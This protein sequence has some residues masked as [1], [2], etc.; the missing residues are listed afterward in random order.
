VCFVNIGPKER[1]K[2]LL[3]GG[4]S[5]AVGLGLFIILQAFA[6]PWWTS[7]ITFPFFF[8]AA[9]GFFQWHDKTC[10]ALVAK[11]VRNLDD[12]N[13]AI[14]DAEMKAGLEQQAKRVRMKSVLVSLGATAIAVVLAL[15]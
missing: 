8:A 13:E 15:I 12:G 6:T 11:G 4:L 3:A 2:R 14:T 7:V 1:Q 10:V 5:L 9:M